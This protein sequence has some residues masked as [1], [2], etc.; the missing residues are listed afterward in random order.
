MSDLKSLCQT[1]PLVNLLIWDRSTESK[2]SARCTTHPLCFKVGPEELT[3]SLIRAY[4]DHFS[5]FQN[6]H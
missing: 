5:I 1:D 2:A 3:F 4:D 6:G